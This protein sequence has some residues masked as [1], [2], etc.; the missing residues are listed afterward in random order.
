M[1]VIS[2][3]C[4]FQDSTGTVVRYS[5]RNVPPFSTIS[6]SGMG[7]LTPPRSTSTAIRSLPTSASSCRR[8]SARPES[9]SCCTPA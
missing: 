5:N 7:R 1:P 9:T 6:C 2:E 4:S 3:I 8:S